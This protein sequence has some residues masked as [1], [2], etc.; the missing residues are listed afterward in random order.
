MRLDSRVDL[1]L[2]MIITQI[3]VSL[4]FS[5]VRASL[6]LTCRP[7]VKYLISAANFKEVTIFI[8]RFQCLI[9]SYR[10][11]TPLFFSVAGSL[12]LGLWNQV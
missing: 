12:C 4:R 2:K 1:A 10:I 6:C 5:F 8:M 3:P 7:G 9:F 11:F